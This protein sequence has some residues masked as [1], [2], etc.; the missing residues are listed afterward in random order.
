MAQ[1]N[2]TMVQGDLRV[3]GKIYGTDNAIRLENANLAIPTLGAGD[4][5]G[6]T[7][8]FFI[9]SG[10]GKNLP[11]TTNN[12]NIH[13]TVTHLTGTTYRLTQ[14]ATPTASNNPGGIYERSGISSD[15]V[16][17]TF[18]SWVSTYIKPSGGIPSTDMSSAVQTS[19]TKADNAIPSSQK[20]A[21][22]GVGSLGSNSVQPYSEMY[23]GY[24][25][26]GDA[27]FKLCRIP[28]DANYGAGVSFVFTSRAYDKASGQVLLWISPCEWENNSV[29]YKVVNL[30]AR[31]NN[32]TMQFFYNE[33]TV[34]G[35]SYVDVYYRVY[36][37]SNTHVMPL[38]MR[39]GVQDML[40]TGAVTLPD[41]AVEMSTR[42]FNVC[43]AKDG[44]GSANTPVYVNSSGDVTPCGD[45][46]TNKRNFPKLNF[47][48][49]G[50]NSSS[51]RYIKVA[52]ITCGI[53]YFDHPFVFRCI[54][55]YQLIYTINLMFQ[56]GNTTKPGI[57]RFN[58]EVPTGFSVSTADVQI[59]YDDSGTSRIYTLWVNPGGYTDVQT[60]LECEN[61]F[62]QYVELI[63]GQYSTSLSG[64]LAPQYIKYAQSITPGN[65]T[66]N[67]ST[68][69][70]MENDGT[71]K[72]CTSLTPIPASY[73]AASATK[74]YKI[75]T[76]EN[77]GGGDPMYAGCM[78]AVCLRDNGGADCQIILSVSFSEYSTSADT[79]PI[80]GKAF[81]LHNRITTIG[82]IRF[83][84]NRVS[85]SKYDIY[86][87][88]NGTNNYLSCQCISGKGVTIHS[89]PSPETITISNMTELTRS[90]A[91]VAQESGQI[92][93]STRPVYI[94]SSGVVRQCSEAG[95]IEIADGPL[96]VYTPGVCY[97]I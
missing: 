77:S 63:N 29:A 55:R 69:I 31:A 59:T 9:P 5:V 42:Y 39:P 11:I 44:V 87:Y 95:Y 30:F 24:V 54:G 75:A 45:S 48:S 14:I 13:T 32:V 86:A 21:A 79:E 85:A 38:W 83:F 96:P 74:G 66:G 7:G 18:G 4:Y 57:L 94:D 33:V 19:L 58:V 62:A 41:G 22:N 17:W 81:T 60:V 91:V 88:T 52:T 61:N 8:D 65:R 90:R 25:V 1:L 27:V 34:D 49:N 76:V 92:G 53:P 43:A 68:P 73:S 20:G 37:S 26:S 3:T 84:V 78:I 10:S 46:L 35:S 40:T 71:L 50:S 67:E 23:K 89:S 82:A 36:G 80:S 16:T 2:D 97:L 15:G 6:S 56:G 51:A 72:P 47:F 12:F 28:K 93:S 70:F 64:A